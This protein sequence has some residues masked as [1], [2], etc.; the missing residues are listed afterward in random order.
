MDNNNQF[1]LLPLG[2]KIDFNANELEVIRRIGAGYTSVVYEG[3]LELLDGGEKK[4]V[5]I[6]VF[7]PSDLQEMKN[8]YR[9]EGFILQSLMNEEQNEDDYTGRVIKIAPVYYG[10]GD[11]QGNSL[12]VMEFIQGDELPALLKTKRVFT[13]KQTL[14]IAWQFFRLLEIMHDKLER[15]Y[16]DMKFENLWM[17]NDEDGQLRVIDLGM[18]QPIKPDAN[19]IGNP[20]LDLLR[21]SI[22][23]FKLASG[24]NLMLDVTNLKQMAEPVIEEAQISWG[25]R[26][27]FKKALSRNPS[28]RYSSASEIKKAFYDLLDYWDFDQTRLVEETKELLDEYGKNRSENNIDLARE[29]IFRSRAMMSVFEIKA[30]QEQLADYSE[31][32]KSVQDAVNASSY[33]EFGKELVKGGAYKAAIDQL[34]IGE[35]IA[36]NQAIF[37]R[38]KHL[39]MIG[40]ELLTTQF[41]PELRRQAEAAVER[42]TAEDYY[43]AYNRFSTLQNNISSKGLIALLL[44]SDI[45]VGVE[46][47]RTLASDGNYPAAAK[48]YRDLEEKFNTFP[49][50]AGSLKEEVGNLD[51]AGEEMEKLSRTLSEAQKIIQSATDRMQHQ[52]W[53]EAIELLT[54]AWT[55]Y[56]HPEI[57]LQTLKEGLELAISSKQLDEACQ[58]GHFSTFVDQEDG[59]LFLIREGIFRLSFLRRLFVQDDIDGAMQEARLLLSDSGLFPKVKEYLKNILENN[60]KKWF[61]AKDMNRLKVLC[62]FVKEYFPAEISWRDDLQRSIDELSDKT[63]PQLKMQIDSLISASVARMYIVYP[64]ALGD[65]VRLWPIRELIQNNKNKGT[66]L[67]EI[68]HNLE[69]IKRMALPISYRNNEIDQ[70]IIRVDEYKNKISIGS[71]KAQ[72]ALDQANLRLEE[73]KKRINSIRVYYAALIKSMETG[74]SPIVQSRIREDVIIAVNDLL[75]DLY[76]YTQVFDSDNIEIQEMYSELLRISCPLGIKGWEDLIDLAEMKKKEVVESINRINILLTDGKLDKAIAETALLE[77]NNFSNEDLQSLKIRILQMQEFDEWQLS[78]ISEME[79]GEYNPEWLNKFKQFNSYE[80]FSFFWHGSKSEI[81]LQTITEKLD[82]QIRHLVNSPETPGYLEILKQWLSLQVIDR[83]ISSHN[84]K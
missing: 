38:W 39:G 34:A 49:I 63:T 47:A 35:S 9:E 40:E 70:L 18:L 33:L 64:P 67:D 6:K 25:L 45:L 31:L 17:S 73:Y 7:K 69:D 1:N 75:V 16:I 52:S 26:E 56:P 77:S 51:C 13:E 29:L 22:M 55:I 19:Y 21:A 62:S 10:M 78:N 11:Y 24:K 54:K 30:T 42:M 27:I 8:T 37:R 74:L 43:G 80:Q 72:N 53:K 61:M 79:K 60:A 65:A 84:N 12:L 46:K 71:S 68:R 28:H 83:A 14:K 41:T 3:W 44:E 23:M 76:S 50:D 59:E 48:L 82:K 15:T 4:H 57:Y 32:I 58:L 2:Q 36:I 66:V 81:Y 5:A 20:R